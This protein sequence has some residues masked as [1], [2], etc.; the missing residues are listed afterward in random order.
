MYKFFYLINLFR[1]IP[2]YLIVKA[3]GDI[4]S[5]QDDTKNFAW[6][7]NATEEDTFFRTFNKLTLRNPCY[8]NFVAFRASDK[9]MANYMIRILLPQKKDLEL[10]GKIGGD[11]PKT[12]AVF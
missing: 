5:L 4:S 10:Y 7:V 12:M 8:R 11:C 2:S 9:K 1:S 6:Y 3:C